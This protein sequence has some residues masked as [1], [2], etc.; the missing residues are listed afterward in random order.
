MGEICG[1]DDG[2]YADCCLLVWD[3]MQSEK[4]GIDNSEDFFFFSEIRVE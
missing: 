3:A 4:K 2:G 1:S